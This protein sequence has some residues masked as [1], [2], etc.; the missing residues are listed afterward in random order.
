MRDVLF[1]LHMGSI[2]QRHQNKANPLWSNH[3]SAGIKVTFRCLSVYKSYDKSDSHYTYTHTHIYTC[4]HIMGAP[5]PEPPPLS[6]RLSSAKL[7][8]NRS[9]LAQLSVWPPANERRT[10]CCSADTCSPKVVTYVTKTTHSINAAADTPVAT[11]V[12]PR[13]EI[14]PENYTQWTEKKNVHVK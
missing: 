11:A 6:P 7:W 10:I 9:G 8:M 13:P 12:V 3:D 4:T 5:N 14:T 2:R 1:A